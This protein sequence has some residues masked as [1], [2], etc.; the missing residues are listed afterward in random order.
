MRR[1]PAGLIRKHV[2]VFEAVARLGH[3]IGYRITP[4]PIMC[5]FLVAISIL[6]PSVDLD[7]HQAGRV[8]L[9]LDHIE[10]GYTCFPD[11]VAGIL[12]RGLREGGHTIRLDMNKDVNDVHDSSLGDRCC[13]TI[14]QHHPKEYVKATPR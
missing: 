14:T 8:I 13:S 4:L 3:H 2:G 12:K 7:Q 9:L 1:I 10:T 5:R 6:S 11:T